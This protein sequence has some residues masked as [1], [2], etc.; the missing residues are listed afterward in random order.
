MLWKSLHAGNLGGLLPQASDHGGSAVTLFWGFSAIKQP[1][2]I[3]SRNSGRGY[4]TVLL[5]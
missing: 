4:P 3:R 2:V 5:M 1:A